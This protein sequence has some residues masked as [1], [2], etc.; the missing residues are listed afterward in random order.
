MTNNRAVVVA[1]LIKQGDQGFRLSLRWALGNPTDPTVCD[2]PKKDDSFGIVVRT[3][4]DHYLQ[5][6][7]SLGV[8]SHKFVI[9]PMLYAMI[10]APREKVPV[11]GQT[12]LF[13]RVAGKPTSGVAEGDI[14]EVPQPD[15]GTKRQLKP[16]KGMGVLHLLDEADPDNNRQLAE[17]IIQQRLRSLTGSISEEPLFAALAN[18]GKAQLRFSE[19]LAGYLVTTGLKPAESRAPIIDLYQSLASMAQAEL[20]F[21]GSTNSFGQTLSERVPIA[22]QLGLLELDSVADIYEHAAMAMHVMSDPAT[23]RMLEEATFT[24][25]QVRKQL[26]L[27]AL[28]G[29]TMIDFWSAPTVPDG[30][31]GEAQRGVQH[32]AAHLL[33]LGCDLIIPAATIDEIQAERNGNVLEIVLSDAAGRYGQAKTYLD[34]LDIKNAQTHG[35]SFQPKPPKHAYVNFDLTQPDSVYPDAKERNLTA[36]EPRFN[37]GNGL[38]E[39]HIVPE[40]PTEIARNIDGTRAYSKAPAQTEAGFNL[41]GFWNGAAG[42][43][44][45]FSDPDAVPT[46]EELKPYLITRRFSLERDLYGAFPDIGGQSHPGI[47]RALNSPPSQ[48]IVPR[49]L[50]SRDYNEFEDSGDGQSN[51]APEVP[52]L[53]YRNN[54]A[55]DPTIFAF[56]IRRGFMPQVPVPNGAVSGW[57]PAAVVDD[58]WAPSSR[59]NGSTDLSKPETYRFFVTSVDTFDL[60]SEPRPV[61]GADVDARD[62]ENPWFFHPTFRT[63]IPAPGNLISI[64]VNKDT[65]NPLLRVTWQMPDFSETPGVDALLSALGKELITRVRVYRR[66]LIAP[67]DLE[68]PASFSLSLTEDPN[69][70]RYESLMTHRGWSRFDEKVVPGS[71][72]QC[73]FPLAYKDRGF[74]YVVGINLAVPEEATPFWASATLSRKLAYVERGEDGSLKAQTRSV[75]E[76]PASSNVAGFPLIVL[77]N[78]DQP[79]APMGRVMPLLAGNL[80]AASPILPLPGVQRDLVLA[81]IL[82]MP[83]VEGDSPWRDTGVSLS[84]GQQAAADTA[85][86]RSLTELR[87]LP[88]LPDDLAID[89]PRLAITRQI[90]ARSFQQPLETKSSNGVK[91]DIGQ[92]MTIGFRGVMQLRWVYESHAAKP[93]LSDSKDAEAVA[94]EVFQVSVPIDSAQAKNAAIF[95]ADADAD[96]GSYKIRF[97]RPTDPR[98]MVAFEEL[99]N[100]LENIFAPKFGMFEDAVGK[101]FAIIEVIKVTDN[102]AVVTARPTDGI[103]GKG[104]GRLNIFLARSVAT[105][106]TSELDADEATDQSVLLPVGGGN[107]EIGCWW[108]APKSS[109]GSVGEHA[110]MAV[111]TLALAPTI[112][113]LGVSWLDVY[114]AVDRSVERLNP[115]DGFANWLPADIRNL[116]DATSNPRLVL[117]W[118]IPE[119]SDPDLRLVVERERKRASQEPDQNLLLNSLDLEQW[120]IIRRIEQIDESENLHTEEVERLANGSGAWMMGARIFIDVEESARDKVLIPPERDLMARDGLLKLPNGVNSLPSFIDYWQ[121]IGDSAAM[122]GN[123]VYRY[124]VQLARP[125]AETDLFLYSPPSP[126][127]EWILP[128]SPEIEVIDGGIVEQD[129]TTELFAPRI[130][131][132]IDSDPALKSYLRMGLT[133]HTITEESTLDW[134]Y[135]ILIRR[136]LSVLMPGTQGSETSDVTRQVGTSLDIGAVETGVITDYDIERSFADEDLELEYEVY[137]QQFI[138][139]NRGGQAIEQLVRSPSGEPQLR[140]KLTVTAPSNSERDKEIYIKRKLVIR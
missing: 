113:P 59:R 135:R 98:E 82:G 71:A 74:E 99:V 101:H 24:P 115:D 136:P 21:V 34:P 102:S 121:K 103:L 1:N 38:V 96:D 95:T 139:R 12:E 19:R 83:F 80:A 77:P 26:K 18:N 104:A 44:D 94:F 31:N 33:G 75:P 89:D 40:P 91:R 81:K 35:A 79:R 25:D 65:N 58:A 63:Q 29:G 17:S 62:T 61:R 130:D 6:D 28:Q 14:E 124:R 87:K 5:A 2:L 125:V 53:L 126:W 36:E 64:I 110:R 122:D 108:V 100:T 76:A 97:T 11:P 50:K 49:P 22:G 118:A 51:V 111:M 20:Y 16:G 116:S 32:I 131:F 3:R 30:D 84:R 67:V 134:K 70:I 105:V 15:G 140:F 119:D 56:D 9:K 109:Q 4:E 54:N 47:V 60:E 7:G 123:Y 23:L 46:L 37:T 55:P 133:A 43:D 112:Q 88:T 52:D 107:R 92:N 86:E 138:I 132:V 42:M 128:E 73:E 68:E 117:R 45:Y 90:I 41:Y 48:A 27:M 120:R 137:V 39:V 93:P 127:T 69:W 13:Q 10:D 78:V 8:D 85:L 66:R 72:G 114:S 57:D 106:R 129:F